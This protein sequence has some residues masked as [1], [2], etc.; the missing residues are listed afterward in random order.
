MD[1]KKLAEPFPAED[2]EWRI[3]R[4]GIGQKGIFCLV[5]AYITARA[6]Q[7]RL[8]DVC[9]AENWRNE[10]PRVIEVNGK[11]AFA[12]GISI[13]IGEE[14]VTKWDVAEPTAEHGS[15]SAPA[16]G[17]FSGAMK[18][19]GAQWG[20]GRYLY[21]LD[22]TFAEVSD[23]GQG[24]QWNYAKIKTDEGPKTFYW[25]TPSLPGWALPKDTDADKVSDVELGEMKQAWRRKFQ[26]DCKDPAELREG[27]SRF[28]ISV[29]GEFPIA[30]ASC[31]TREALA[32]C[33]KRIESTTDVGGVDSDVPF[34]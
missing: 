13:R 15:V 28:V 6:I 19:A 14:W 21:Y 33:V 4:S 3:S 8:D 7:K 11:S 9:G 25:K 32:K 12:C 34:E 2:I 5:L 22:E 26:P 30:D 27:L 10:E 16:K 24:R 31:W 20:I 18:R 1:L 29:V 17:G 23:N